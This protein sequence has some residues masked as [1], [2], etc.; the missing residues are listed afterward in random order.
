MPDTSP[1]TKICTIDSVTGFCLGCGRTGTE[2]GQWT[3][4]S[5]E[6]RIALKRA[7]PERMA[8]LA[9]RDSRCVVRR[10]GR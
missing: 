6:E 7:L 5:R 1:C 10:K 2:I 4:M 3:S 9:Q 8:I